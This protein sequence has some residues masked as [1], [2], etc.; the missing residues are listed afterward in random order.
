MGV[1]N[2]EIR[3][4]LPKQH[5]ALIQFLRLKK[6]SL[7]KA[8]MEAIRLLGEKEYSDDPSWDAVVKRLLEETT[9]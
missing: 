2:Y 6:G 8:V 1:P 4:K 5:Y 9:I 3:V 7:R